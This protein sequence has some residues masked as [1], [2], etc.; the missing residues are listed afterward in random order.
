MASIDYEV[1]L[2]EEERAIQEMVHRFAKEVLR[3]AGTELDA[4]PDPQDVI[5]EGSILWEVF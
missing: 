4:M 2:T 1:E 5:A 3:P